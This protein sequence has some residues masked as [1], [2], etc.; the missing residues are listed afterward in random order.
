MSEI[1]NLTELKEEYL[2]GDAIRQQP[3]IICQPAISKDS[4][5]QYMQK[6]I[7]I[8]AT[9]SKVSALLITGAYQNQEDVAAYFR[10]LAK[11]ILDEAVL[12]NDF[13]KEA[14]FLGFYNQ[15]CQE[16]QE[17]IGY[18]ITLLS[19]YRTTLAQQMADPSW[20]HQ[21]AINMVLDICAALAHCRQ[22][23]YLYTNLKPE[24]IAVDDTGCYRICDLGLVPLKSLSYASLPEKYR[25][26]YTAPEVSDSLSLLSANMDV[27]A[28]GIILYQLF[29]GGKL[30]EDS[31]VPAEFADYALWQI[32]EAACCADPAMRY[33][34]PD[35]LGHALTTYAQQYGLSDE[36]IIPVVAPAQDAET[37]DCGFLTEEENER[38]LAGLL[39]AIPDEETPMDVLDDLMAES[40]PETGVDDLEQILAQADDLIM[41]EAPQPVVAPAVIDVQLPVIEDIPEESAE[42]TPV[43][44]ILDIPETEEAPVEQPA[45]ADPETVPVEKEEAQEDVPS[46]AISTTDEVEDD[47]NYIDEEAISRKK[48]KRGWLIAL[49]AAAV[50]LITGLIY[51]HFFYTQRIDGITVQ[52]KDDRV[53]IVLNTA[54]SDELLSIVCIDTYGNTLRSTVKDG[55]ATVSG[56]NLNAHYRLEVRI[57]GPHRLVGD[58]TATFT[59]TTHTQIMN[60][61]AICGQLDGSAIIS[62]SI[63]GNHID[64]WDLEYEAEDD[65]RQFVSF[66]GTSVTIN[67]LHVGKEYTFK[68]VPQQQM[69]V[70]GACEILFTAQKVVAAQSLR[71]TGATSDSLSVAWDL[72]EGIA[73]Q[74]WSV[75][76]YNGSGYDKSLETSQLA[77]TFEGLDFSGSYTVLVTAKGMTKSVT[78]N[79]PANPTRVED[80]SYDCADLGAVKISWTFTGSAPENGWILR[81]L[82]D[83]SDEILVECSET[84]ATLPKYPGSRYRIQLSSADGTVIIAPGFTFDTDAPHAFDQFGIKKDDVEL[85]MCRTPSKNGWTRDDVKNEDYTTTFTPGEKASFVIRLRA[86]H[87]KSTENVLTTIVIR[88]ADGTPVGHFTATKV[89]KQMWKQSYGTLDIPQLPQ[90]AGSYQVEIYFN[91]MMI[92]TQN[93]TIA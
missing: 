45:P 36:P 74:V 48:R 81:Y 54:V 42:E 85:Y 63:L 13:S 82:V 20:T 84:Q 89:W 62:F 51:Y 70:S 10:S 80:Y 56:L 79:I 26:A 86:N 17:G 39:A 18:Q 15:D 2:L 3:G 35:A 87:E 44:P 47:E 43:L 52:T 66:T 16:L 55:K 77:A 25:S 28:L 33:E 12:I 9:Q 37:T 1:D 29:N 73:D 31:K 60:L 76:C 4:G 40:E 30:P 61:S 5:N 14:G 88:N 64:A 50:L 91:E 46:P 92:S 53:E 21:N 34:S 27:Y 38:L 32:I 90:Q 6:T 23:G 72:P 11:E 59:T 75:R 68:L 69:P 41:H 8:P 78:L 65:Q 24:N 7:T 67:G 71:V 19:A 58:T 83:G 93:F 49:C 57:N 22:V